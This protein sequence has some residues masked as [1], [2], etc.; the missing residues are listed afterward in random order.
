MNV[1]SSDDADDGDGVVRV[2]PNSNAA[3][4]AFCG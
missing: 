1:F 2:I 4:L 3:A